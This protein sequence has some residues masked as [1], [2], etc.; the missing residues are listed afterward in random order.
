MSW[1]KLELGWESGFLNRVSSVQFR[2][3]PPNYTQVTIGCADWME[4]KAAIAHLTAG[5]R[6]RMQSRSGLGRIKKGQARASSQQAVTPDQS[7]CPAIV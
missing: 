7:T 2:P 4:R 1:S 3:G 6:G 5:L